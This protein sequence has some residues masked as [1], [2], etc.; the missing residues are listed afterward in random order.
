MQ[1]LRGHD[2]IAPHRL[3]TACRCRI[4]DAAHRLQ[5][6]SLAM[7]ESNKFAEVPIVPRV[8]F[9]GLALFGSTGGVYFFA[10]DPEPPKREST[11]FAP[12]LHI[13]P[14]SV[15]FSAQF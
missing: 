14:G 6:A 3:A 2:A 5:I 15:A 4:F 12:T 9:I 8:A 7:L 13:T 10:T 1:S 11:R